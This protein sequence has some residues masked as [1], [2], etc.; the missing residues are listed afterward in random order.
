M[1]PDPAFV[2]EKP[3]THLADFP[4]DS[5]FGA[6]RPTELNFLAFLSLGWNSEEGAM[7]RRMNGQRPS[8]TD[9]VT[10]TRRGHAAGSSRRSVPQLNAA[11]LSDGIARG[12]G[13][14][15]WR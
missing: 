3:C 8:S 1:G 5:S 4:L 10:G 9:K 11:L 12:T 6:Q 15:C 2:V 7:P 14:P 13:L